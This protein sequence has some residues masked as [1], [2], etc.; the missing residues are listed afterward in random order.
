MRREVRRHTLVRAHADPFTRACSHHCSLLQCVVLSAGSNTHAEK[1]AADYEQ[2]V[3]AVQQA[4]EQIDALKTA[5]Q[6]AQG[7]W[8][9]STNAGTRVRL[10]SPVSSSSRPLFVC[11][12]FVCSVQAQSDDVVLVAPVSSHAAGA[13]LEGS[14]RAHGECA[15]REGRGRRGVQE[16]AEED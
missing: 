15:G 2:A 4:E 12:L 14:H 3:A 1:E 13:E 10:T 11:L 9:H 6:K 5:I 16:A 7:P 8:Q